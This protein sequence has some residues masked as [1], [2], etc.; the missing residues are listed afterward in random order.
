[1]SENFLIT[2]GAGFIGSRLA[3]RL[4]DE[5]NKVFIFDNLSTGF[6]RN[7]PPKASFHKVD[8]SDY[9]SLSSINL[10]EKIDAVFHLA[11]QSSGPASFKDPAMDICWNYKAT[12]NILKYAEENN[13][14]RFLFSSS[15]SVYGEVKENDYIISEG[16]KY[17]PSSY[18]GCNKL[19]SENLIRIFAKNSSVI[20]TI[21]RLFNV[22]GPGQNMLNMDQGMVS[23]Y[24]SYL[25]NDKLVCVKGALDRFRDFI[26][27]DDVVDVFIRSVNNVNT[28]NET[29]NAGTGIKTTVKELLE[30]MLKVYKKDNFDEW[31]YVQGNTPGDIKGTVANMDKLRRTLNWTPKYLLADGLRNMKEWVDETIDWWRTE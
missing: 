27:I 21:F 25:L 12:Y 29:F 26:Y 11:A 5:G 31:V 13:I 1:M 9:D 3:K 2:G 6:E 23:I 8:V 4:V 10:N 18:Y 28:Y 22:Y 14:R 30:S 24:M 19:A 17:E 20:P 16:H 15:M 7:V